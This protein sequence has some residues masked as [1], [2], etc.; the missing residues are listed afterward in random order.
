[1]LRCLR[2]A[3]ADAYRA[4]RGG[5]GGDGGD[6]G[7]GSGDT[8]VEDPD[9]IQLTAGVVDI[10]GGRNLFTD[11]SFRI[12]EGEHTMIVGPSG[13]GKTSILRVLAGLWPLSRG[14]LTRPTTIGRGGIFFL[15]QMPYITPG[16]LREQVVYPGTPHKQRRRSSAGNA[17]KTAV[18]AGGG[19]DDV[20]VV[21]ESERVRDALVCADLEWLVGEWGLDTAAE[22]GIASA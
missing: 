20:V 17:G 11:V 12:R 15:P 21:S 18:S 9:V 13:C 5:G 2:A 3:D 1:M 10:P 7:G 8:F 22:V 6:S 16:S 19:G 4:R 14:V